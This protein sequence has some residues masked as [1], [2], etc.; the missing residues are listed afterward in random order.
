MLVEALVRCDELLAPCPPALRAEVVE[1][2]RARDLAQPRLSGAA[3]GI[4]PV[5]EAQR[6]LEGGPGQLLRDPAVAREPGEVAVDVVEMRFGGL[7]KRHLTRCTPPTGGMSQKCYRE[8]VSV[9]T[10][11]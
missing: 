3:R 2:D 1:R 8:S 7:G 4:E 9:R 5:P 11:G 6:P 10:V